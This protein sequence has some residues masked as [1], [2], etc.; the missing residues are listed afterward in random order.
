MGIRVVN[1]SNDDCC[2]A[3]TSLEECRKVTQRIMFMAINKILKGNSVERLF[4]FKAL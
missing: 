4:S 1:I 2:E 3:V